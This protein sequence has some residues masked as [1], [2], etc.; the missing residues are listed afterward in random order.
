MNSGSF[1]AGWSWSC[2][3]GIWPLLAFVLV[4]LVVA[5]YRT[6]APGR[7]RESLVV[8][9]IVW[10]AWVVLGCELLSLA[11]AVR[12][13]PMIL[14]WALP[15]AGL[16]LLGW[17]RRERIA[18]V[19]QLP[20]GVQWA[21]WVVLAITAAV[22]VLAGTVAVASPP[23]TADAL[24][25]HMPRQVYWMQAH[26]VGHFPATTIL[27]TVM[28]PMAEFAGLHFMVLSQSDFY[29]TLVQWWALIL[30]A[31]AASLLAR[32]LG[33]GATGQAM[34]ALLLV[35][36]PMA[37]M[38]ASS[39]K[40]DLVAAL[41]LVIL[42]LYAAKILRE[43]QCGPGRWAMLGAA[44]GLAVLTKLTGAIFAVPM[45]A[46]V[47]LWLAI[48]R[49]PVCIGL[50]ATVL[51]ITVALNAGHWVRNMR[52]YDSPHASTLITWGK[53]KT[54]SNETHTP[55][56]IASNA[57]RNLALHAGT[58]WPR[59]NRAV[60]R[61]VKWAHQRMGIEVNDARTTAYRDFKVVH[62]ARDESAAGAPIHLLL[63]A[64][65]A[66]ILVLNAAAIMRR[67]PLALLGIGAA[68]WWRISLLF[69]G[70]AGGFL[71][72]CALLKWQP[73]HARLHLGAMAMLAP[74]VA[75]ALCRD[76]GRGI[77]AIVV[78]GLLLAPLLSTM[79]WNDFRP[80]AGKDS[81]FRTSRN[82]LLVRGHP[83]RFARSV[84]E[85][86]SIARAAQARIIGTRLRLEY[87]YQAR[88]LSE[89]D[90]PPRFTAP[91]GHVHP[92]MQP[93]PMPDLF[94][95]QDGKFP[96]LR[97]RGTGEL[98]YV[99]RTIEIYRFLVPM[100]VAQKLYEAGVID[101]LPQLP[102]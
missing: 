39:A 34:A 32:E 86:V 95:D 41:W 77:G 62:A 45:L 5:S 44:A 29:S 15:C 93:W 50:A 100:P 4:T 11:E 102:Q 30:A 49:K 19:F 8:A 84:D 57:I 64:A 89:L 70:V 68:D 25:Y 58:P 52:V 26:H 33:A 2:L 14:W 54:H 83:Q 9:A 7:L 13:W 47:G 88:L 46:V 22:V 67:R 20:R 73:W 24:I 87:A 36:N 63:A 55:A 23:N 10:G 91:L 42:A 6:A 97:D 40:N 74:V 60:E 85:S 28:P 92:G 101:E 94:I 76:R 3:W 37:W 35:S 56:A 18:G 90:A 96:R 75:A 1:S 27:Q 82:A 48:K 69:A 17:I 71:V 81:V 79:L 72:F 59:A 21:A 65:A 16:T 80:L 31:L 78:G 51:A 98:L 43:G 12:F 53:G 38:Q 66:V 99:V 61:A